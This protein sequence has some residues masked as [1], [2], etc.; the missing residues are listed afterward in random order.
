VYVLVDRAITWFQ[1]GLALVSSVQ[2]G[3]DEVC[4]YAPPNV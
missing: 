4:F 2:G 3:C 1:K